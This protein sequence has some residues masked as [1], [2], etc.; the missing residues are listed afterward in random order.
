MVGH[1]FEEKVQEYLFGFGSFEFIQFSKEYPSHNGL[2]KFKCHS[3][4][5]VGRMSQMAD[6][7]EKWKA[8]CYAT[9]YYL[10]DGTRWAG[11]CNNVKRF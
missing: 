10:P 2:I 4:L 6:Y 9:E 3:W 7:I 8:V 5:L 11:Y 1:Q